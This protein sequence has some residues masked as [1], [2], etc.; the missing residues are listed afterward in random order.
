MPKVSRPRWTA[1]KLPLPDAD[2]SVQAI[3]EAEGPLHANPSEKRL[4]VHPDH[5]A[6]PLSS[7]QD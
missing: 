1:L 4:A 6:T 2:Q 3:N 7:W 5:A